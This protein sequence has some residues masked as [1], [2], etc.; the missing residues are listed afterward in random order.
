MMVPCRYY[1]VFP[2]RPDQTRLTNEELFRNALGIHRVPYGSIGKHNGQRWTPGVREN[3]RLS[4]FSLVWPGAGCESEGGERFTL[5]HPASCF[6]DLSSC[7]FKSS[8]SR[9]PGGSQ[10]RRLAGIEM[11]A[12]SCCLSQPSVLA[13]AQTGLSEA[14]I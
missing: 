3:I 10:S 4:S 14:Q 9:R 11:P 13:A 6:S 1:P 12:R 8:V 2:T 5:F 7:L